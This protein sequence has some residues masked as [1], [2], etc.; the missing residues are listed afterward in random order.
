MLVSAFNSSAYESD[1]SAQTE[2]N[3]YMESLDAKIAQFQN[4]VQQLEQ[5]LISSDLLKFFVDFG[6]GA[7]S[8]LDKVIDKFGT[9]NTLTTVIS[10]VRGA[11][12]HGLTKLCYIK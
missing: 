5:D 7:V 1:N 4:R 12:G 2:L 8:W 3:S 10:G 11:Q 9:L 6:T